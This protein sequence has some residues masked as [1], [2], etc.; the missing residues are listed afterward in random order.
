MA[1]VGRV[2]SQDLTLIMFSQQQSH[3]K[4]IFWS[5]MVGQRVSNI[6]VGEG[7]SSWILGTS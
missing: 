4:M 7:R 5:F 6:I 2:D 3:I 1:R